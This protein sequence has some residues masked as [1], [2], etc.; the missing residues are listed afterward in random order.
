MTKSADEKRTIS[1]LTLCWV[2]V[3][4]EREGCLVA[5]EDDGACRI[6]SWCRLCWCTCD[7]VRTERYSWA[8]TC[9]CDVETVAF[10]VHQVTVNGLSHIVR[11]ECISINNR[12][13]QLI[14]ADTNRNRWFRYE[15]DDLFR[16]LIRS[17]CSC[18]P[19]HKLTTKVELVVGLA[20]EAND[21]WLRWC[22]QRKRYIRENS[23]SIAGRYPCWHLVL[24]CYQFHSYCS[25]N[26]R[27]RCC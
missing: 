14:V 4:L 27:G 9:W 16:E 12:C 1:N 15:A 2:I 13:C 20:W 22:Q 19:C 6:L 25:S 5:C 21:I 18:I 7:E 10:A 23:R 26:P 11:Q 17:R 24:R 8:A 3:V